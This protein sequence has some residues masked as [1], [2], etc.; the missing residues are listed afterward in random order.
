MRRP[1]SVKSLEE[2]GRVRLSPSFFM[3]DMLYSEIANFY[4]IPNI[5]D[6]PDLAIEAATQLCEHLLEPLQEKFGRISIRS[7]YRAP[8]VNRIGNERNHSCAQNHKSHAGHMFD[9]LDADGCMGAT[10]SIVVNSYVDH[11]EASGEWEPLA[12]W[13]HDHLPYSLM[14]FYPRLGA[15][16]L[17][18]HEKPKRKIYSYTPPRLGYLTRPG[19]DNHKGC[20]RHLYEHV[21]PA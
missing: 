21:I 11:F 3:R 8:E 10:A 16:N 18:W 6:H 5:P 7:A 20:H 13:I 17:E 12:W 1:A 2:L 4:G 14:Q 19:M 15:F 9:R